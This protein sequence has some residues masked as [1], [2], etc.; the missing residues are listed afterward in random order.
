[1]NFNTIIK[2][3]TGVLASALLLVSCTKEHGETAKALEDKDFNNKAKVQ[4]YNAA[5]GTQRTFAYADGKRLNGAAF[6]YTNTATHTGSGLTFA[7]MPGLRAFVVRDTL[8]TSVQP[9][10][11]FAEDFQANKSYTIFLYDTMRFIKQK[12]VLNDIEPVD[13]YTARIRFANFAWLKAGVPPNVDVW[14]KS[15]NTNIF[16]DIPYTTV[17]GFMN[18]QGSTSDSLFVREAG[19]MIEIA[20]AGFTFQPL[21][22]YTLILRGGGAFTRTLASFETK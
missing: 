7:V 22:H 9:P 16:S 18:V 10:L 19:T 14:S 1:M 12:T 5:L 3:G 17:T 11:A 4:V 20:K 6:I 15:Q 13:A 21:K 8:G 2:T